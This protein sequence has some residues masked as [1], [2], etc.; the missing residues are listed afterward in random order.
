MNIVQLMKEKGDRVSVKFDGKTLYWN[1]ATGC[2]EVW[3]TE[4]APVQF[5]SECD[6][7]KEGVSELIKQ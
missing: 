2:W 4:R 1:P 7:E 5:L 3:R 6:T